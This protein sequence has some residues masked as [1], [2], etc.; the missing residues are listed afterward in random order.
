MDPGASSLSAVPEIDREGAVREVEP[1]LARG[2]YDSQQLPQKADSLLV[3]VRPRTNRI[4]FSA[5]LLHSDVL[6]HPGGED[7]VE[8]ALREW[9]LQCVC[10]EQMIAMLPL[11]PL[12]LPQGGQVVPPGREAGLGEEIDGQS[13]A[14]TAVEDPD[15]LRRQAEPAGEASKEREIVALD[16]RTRSDDLV[17]QPFEMPGEE[18]LPVS[19]SIVIGAAGEVGDPLLPEK[20]EVASRA[21]ELAA[22]QPKS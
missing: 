7:G 16:P 21:G 18:L 10:D 17:F 12:P 2:G 5:S 6:D 9:K 4:G 13:V 8:K 19:E 22:V 20:T 15:L 1:E 11:A 3:P 14:A